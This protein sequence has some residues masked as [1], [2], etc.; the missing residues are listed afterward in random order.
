MT[1]TDQITEIAPY[2]GTYFWV[3]NN[4]RWGKAF[5]RRLSHLPIGGATKKW[6]EL[7]TNHFQIIIKAGLRIWVELTRI[8]IRPSR[9]LRSLERQPGYG[10]DQINS[11]LTFL[12]KSLYK[13]Q[14][15]CEYSA[16]LYFRLINIARKVW[17]YKDLESHRIQIF[18]WKYGSGSATLIYRSSL[19]LFFTVN[20][21]LINIK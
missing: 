9:K 16:L 17:L 7:S 21:L 11:S 3:T 15:N 20:R 13:N 12:L 8:Q 1:Q 14:Y 19:N 10:F 2:V 4:C 6:F 5:G 18:F